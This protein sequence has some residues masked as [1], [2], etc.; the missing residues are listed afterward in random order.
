MKQNLD[1]NYNFLLNGAATHVG[2]VRKANEDSM[3]TFETANMKVFVVCDGMGGHVGGQVASQTAITAIRDFLINNIMLDP[4]EAIYN[5]IIAANEAVLNRTRQQPELAGMGSTCV[6]LVVTSDGK[7]YYGH[8][9]DSRVYIIANHRITQLTEDH[10]VVYEMFKAGIIKTREEM[11]RH[12]RKNEITNALGL[13]NMQP[14]T[15]CDAPIEPE[16][17][18]CFLLCSDGL[19]GMV[20]DEQIQRVISKHEIPIQQ[21][22]ETLVQMAN[23]NGGVD[24]ITVELVEFAVGAQQ[25][26]NNK[27]QKSKNWKKMLL[28]ALPVVLILAGG[29]VW[30]FSKQ[31]P[32]PDPEPQTDL[33]ENQNNEKRKKPEVTLN[34]PIGQA[35]FVTNPIDFTKTG[36]TSVVEIKDFPDNDAIVEVFAIVPN[37]TIKI[38]ETAGK[39]IIIKWL[40]EVKDTIKITCK[41]TKLEHCTIKIP[42]IKANIQA[43][44][45]AN[46]IINVML[47]PISYKLDEPISISTKDK[48]KR[49]SLTKGKKETNDESVKCDVT[50]AN[51]I[52]IQFTKPKYSNPVEVFIETKTGKYK[53]IIPVQNPQEKEIPAKEEEKVKEEEPR[54][55]QV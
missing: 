40:K 15:V 20:G 1:S 42:M 11:E 27:G 47:D 45:S 22:A 44:Q 46:N 48:N 54:T 43:Q 37:Q 31:Q 8:V 10:S 7:V 32:K 25:I 14:P 33:T 53:F 52:V 36:E 12:P 18:N 30:W 4:R 6:M 23:A 28:F 26:S 21:R 13:P 35:T 49:I 17:G 24:N 39:Y 50:D 5:S 55:T 38:E 16:S 51:T 29:A 41:T 34:L 2:Q 9:G 19:T 3:A